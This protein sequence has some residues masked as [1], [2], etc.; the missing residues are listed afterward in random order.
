MDDT[1]MEQV[2]VEFKQEILSVMNKYAE[3]IGPQ[4]GD[5]GQTVNTKET[6]PTDVFVVTN[7]MDMDTSNSF[8][9]GYSITRTNPSMLLGMLMRITETIE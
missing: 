8:L 6:I 7:W 4:N 9:C 3:I 2:W 1:H 5:E